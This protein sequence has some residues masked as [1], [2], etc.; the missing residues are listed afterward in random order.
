MPAPD[1]LAPSVVFDPGR[2]SC[3]IRELASDDMEGRAPGS[4][5][6][7]LA[8]AYITE[9][10][11]SISLETSFQ[12]VPLVGITTESSPLVVAKA[13]DRRRLDYG[14]A[15]MAWTP[16]Q[17]DSVSVTLSELVFVGYGV[18]A[19]EYG[20]NDFKGFDAAGKILLVL[21]NDPPIADSGDVW[22]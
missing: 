3:H 5:G 17:I 14:N 18:V 15:F 13:N 4:K 8:T 12:A 16:R 6:E 7:E 19:P 2:A 1:P 20:W 21:V 22:R 9:V 11:R 10:F